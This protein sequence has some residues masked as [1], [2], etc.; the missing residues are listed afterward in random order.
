MVSRKRPASS[1]QDDLFNEIDFG[2]GSLLIDSH[3][4][5]LPDVMQPYE[6]RL[7]HS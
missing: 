4:Y 6:A 3:L 2:D 7:S 5:A 1:S